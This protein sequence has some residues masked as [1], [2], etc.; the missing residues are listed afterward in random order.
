[1]FDEMTLYRK[2]TERVNRRAVD[3]VQL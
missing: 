2:R 3:C 1:M